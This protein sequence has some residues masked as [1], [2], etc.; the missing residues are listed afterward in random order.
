MTL[1]TI[2]FIKNLYDTPFSYGMLN[3]HSISSLTYSTLKTIGLEEGSSNS[4]LQ[5]S[6]TSIVSP[7]KAIPYDGG[8]IPPPSPSLGGTFQ[9]LIG[10]N[11]NA[12]SFS[13]G[14]H[15]PQYYMT[16]VESMPFYLFDVF[17]NKTFS[18]SSFLARGNIILG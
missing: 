1:T 13:G 14:S 17:G 18:S 9:Q 16:L 7:F 5:G 10:P 8:H 12:S 15:G 4:P 2:P 6:I 11:T 3:F